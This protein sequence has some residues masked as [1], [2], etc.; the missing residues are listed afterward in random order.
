[1]ACQGIVDT[2]GITGN[3]TYF[4]CAAPMLN[5]PLPKRRAMLSLLPG[6]APPSAMVTGDSSKP[7][8][9]PAPSGSMVVV[10]G[11]LN[12]LF[13]GSATGRPNPALPASRWMAYSA[14]KPLVCAS[15]PPVV[16]RFWPSKVA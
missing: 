15:A 10:I 8:M 12:A 11:Q 6:A 7:G 13:A 9:A 2:Q 4:A 16:V 14:S 5:V 1:L 3:D